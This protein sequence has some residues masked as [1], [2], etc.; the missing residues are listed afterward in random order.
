MNVGG[1]K[2]QSGLS[3][4]TLSADPH[5]NTQPPQQQG[6]GG[7]GG[8]GVS[9]SGSMSNV[10]GMM[11]EMLRQQQE[12]QQQAADQQ[13]EL[14]RLS[15][16]EGVEGGVK[17][18]G[19][20][21]PP[22]KGRR[23]GVAEAKPPNP[24]LYRASGMPPQAPSSAPMPTNRSGSGGLGG[25]GT[26][27]GG[28]AGGK[29]AG[30]GP[31]DPRLSNPDYDDQM[32]EK[33]AA[34]AERNRMREEA[35]AAKRSTTPVNMGFGGRTGPTKSRLAPPPPKDGGPAPI[36][37]PPVP[38]RRSKAPKEPVVVNTKD[39]AAEKKREMARVAASAAGALGS[40]PETGGVRGGGGGSSLPP[41]DRRALAKQ[42]GRVSA[43]ATGLPPATGGFKTNK[44]RRP[45]L[46]EEERRKRKEA[47]MDKLPD[48]IAD[49][50]PMQDST[51]W[52][53]PLMRPLFQALPFPG[54]FLENLPQ[55]DE[56]DFSLLPDPNAPVVD[57]GSDWDE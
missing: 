36:T 12:L 8:G 51:I 24:R 43:S 35:K 6:F 25:A 5:F 3:G 23:A 39:R 55:R 38:Q 27:G 26:T 16:G 48:N 30:G 57:P 2:F 32:A 52:V 14:A 40:G 19:V 13:H 29:K 28:A 7:N 22:A 46:S 53:Y 18:R 34:V 17:A 21:Q 41:V 20:S 1:V 50:E 37:G 9:G 45:K 42:Y 4:P 47:A 10:Q 44:V 54:K 31:A 56:A 33:A 15:R 11:A 49:E